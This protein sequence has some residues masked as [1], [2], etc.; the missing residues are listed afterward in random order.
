MYLRNYLFN[1]LQWKIK[2]KK[3]SHLYPPPK[4]LSS[5]RLLYKPQDVVFSLP[6]LVPAPMV[7]TEPYPLIRMILAPETFKDVFRYAITA[8]KR[9]IRFKCAKRSPA[10]SAIVVDTMRQIVKLRNAKSAVVT[11]IPLRDAG[12]ANDATDAAILRR[13]AGV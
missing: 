10:D 5:P 2:F 7:L 3:F 1:V 4:S 9:G 12:S 8:K 13:R 6:R 11:A